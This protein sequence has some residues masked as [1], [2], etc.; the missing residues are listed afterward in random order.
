MDFVA[1]ASS[2]GVR[3]GARLL[4]DLLLHVVLVRAQLDGGSRERRLVRRALDLAAVALDDA[5]VA[6]PQLG[7]IAL[8]RGRSPCA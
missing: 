5:Q 6:K 3:H 7:A 1:T 8:P 2:S 4:E